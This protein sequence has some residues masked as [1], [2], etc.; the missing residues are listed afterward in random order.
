MQKA[1][2]CVIL[3][4]CICIYL[5]DTGICAFLS[6]LLGAAERRRRQCSAYTPKRSIPRHVQALYDAVESTR[7]HPTMNQGMN[8][9]VQGQY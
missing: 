6:P 4:V 2:G 7:E 9:P 1:I 5:C 8:T 3:V